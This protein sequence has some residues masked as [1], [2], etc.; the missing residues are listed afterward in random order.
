M[1]ADVAAIAVRSLALL[2]L[3]QAVGGTLFDRLLCAQIPAVCARVR[4][5]SVLG[6]CC[7][8]CLLLLQLP[9]TAARMAGDFAG[10]LAPALLGIAAH[11]SQAVACSVMAAGLLLMALGLSRGPRRLALLGV[12]LTVCGPTLTGHTSTHPQRALLAPLLSLHVLLAA[13][14]T[15]SLWP[16]LLTLRFEPPERAMIALRRFSL[17]ALWLVPCIAVAGLTM[18]VLLIDGPA[19]LQRP[20]GILVIAKLALFVALLALAALNRWRYTP[21]LLSAPLSSTR[22]LRR[23]LRAEY[24]MITAVLA[25]TATL[26][27]LFSP[28]D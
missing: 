22:L 2:M 20:Y 16:L 21:A 12:A 14:W 1:G 4:R 15:G 7:G 11:S 8:A 19:A 18:F 9:L 17:W 10:A 23:S 6:A 24:L 25:L 26:T 3:C 13:F 27:A 5:I 28:Q